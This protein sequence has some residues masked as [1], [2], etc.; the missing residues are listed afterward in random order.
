MTTD[1]DQRSGEGHM[2]T[3]IIVP[4]DLE[5]CERIDDVLRVT[6]QIAEANNAEVHL[7]SI[8][9][10]APAVVAQQLPQGYERM[11][12]KTVEQDLANLIDRMDVTAG[13]V[14][15]AIRFGGVYQEILAH[16][17]KTGADLIV[18]GSHKP[19][20]ADYLLGSNASRV[21]RHAECSVFVVR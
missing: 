6:A 11:A 21:V 4:I 3:K 20:V 14:T 8:I 17:K 10:A 5:D 2:F 15:T 18:I 13:R 16:A 1:A 12:A 9:D 19:N 7:L